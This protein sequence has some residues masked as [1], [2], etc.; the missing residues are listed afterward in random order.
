MRPW[1]FEERASAA[2]IVNDIREEKDVNAMQKLEKKA[3]DESMTLTA[4]VLYFGD[5]RKWSV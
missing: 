5:P 4:V 3:K 1:T 2:E